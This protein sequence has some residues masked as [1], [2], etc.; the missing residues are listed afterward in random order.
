MSYKL[1]NVYK[2]NEVLQL[3]E[4][5]INNLS[6]GD[7][8]TIDMTT[9]NPVLK[10]KTVNE[11]LGD[12]L[13]VNKIESRN[14]GDNLTLEAKGTGKIILDNVGNSGFQVI[15]ES[16]DEWGIVSLD[17]TQALGVVAGNRTFGGAENRP[18][19][20]GNTFTAGAPTAW[21]SLWVQPVDDAEARLIVGNQTDTIASASGQKMYVKGGISTNTAYK[22]D[23]KL[24][25]DDTGAYI[26]A[27][28]TNTIYHKIASQGATSQHIHSLLP[29]NG[30]LSHT[31]N[32]QQAFSVDR[33]S[34][35]VSL[36]IVLTEVANFYYRGNSFVSLT[37]TDNYSFIYSLVADGL[38]DIELRLYNENAGVQIGTIKTQTVGAGYTQGHHTGTI[39]GLPSLDTSISLQAKF[40]SGSATFIR[41]RY[42]GFV[43]GADAI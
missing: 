4:T 20:G 36:N 16:A 38:A 18:S 37:S 19:I 41:L 35:I 6:D 11:V 23:N 40:V 24:I 29:V 28:S 42:A 32:I 31:F 10:A 17:S 30:K 33:T 3:S 7:L 27:N 2:I 15:N 12:P 26:A 8:L 14:A 43:F 39:N 5:E 22:I 9:L 34:N 1:P 13:E 21:A 25:H